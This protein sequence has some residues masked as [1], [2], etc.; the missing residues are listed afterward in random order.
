RLGDIVVAT[1]LEAKHPVDLVVARRQKQDRNVGGVSNLPADVQPVEF[2]HT[3]VEND[4]VRSVSGETGQGFL[5][6]ARLEHGHPGL[7]ERDPADLTDMQA[8]ANDKPAANS[9]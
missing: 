9:R 6:V 5:A 2:R 1:D 4:E 8:V 7:P 3:D